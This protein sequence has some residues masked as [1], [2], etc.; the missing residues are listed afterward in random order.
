LEASSLS[1]TSFVRFKALEELLSFIKDQQNF[2]LLQR[3]INRL[4][5]CVEKEI[6]LELTNVDTGATRF[7]LY[8]VETSKLLRNSIKQR[9]GVFVVPA[10]RE[11]EWLFGSPE[12]RLE[13]AQ[14]SNFTRLVVVH[15]LRDQTYGNMN[16][17]QEELMGSLGS[18]SP[19]CVKE[20]NIKAPIMTVGSD[21]GERKIL[22]QSHSEFSG[23]YVVEDVKCEEKTYRRLIFLNNPNTIQSEV[24]LEFQKKR[25]KEYHT[26]IFGKLACEHH[27]LMTLSFGFL[28]SFFSEMKE[29]SQISA[30]LI[31][32]GGGLLSSFLINF[33]PHLELSVVEIDSEMLK[34]AKDYFGLPTEKINV[35]IDDGLKFIQ[36]TESQYNL[37]FI[38]ADSKS[39]KEGLSCPPADF[40]EIR[41][42]SAFRSKMKPHA[43]MVLNLVCRNEELKKNYLSTIHSAFPFVLVCNVP[44]E[45]NTILFCLIDIPKV[46]NSNSNDSIA[47]LV[48]QS[49]QDM[50]KHANAKQV[51]ENN[52][53]KNSKLKK[54]SL[55]ENYVKELVDE[56]ESLSLAFKILKL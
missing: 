37:I 52:G 46:P 41:H 11:S 22:H 56:S 1:Q 3:G 40:L 14:Q 28:E 20:R 6:P 7:L 10:G 19:A 5:F 12:G 43:I 17:I 31:G 23:D 8:I 24:E 55:F 50:Q 33:M 30:L 35:I 18:L 13:L 45:V 15:L 32:L 47:L 42:L 51:P 26:P 25:G 4:G 53:K 16:A 36:S 9:F 54:A 39:T 44:N 38:D 49:I 29:S 48:Q 21:V 2:A 34:V 27:R